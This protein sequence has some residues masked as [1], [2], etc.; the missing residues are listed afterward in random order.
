MPEPTI[1]GRTPQQQ[2]S[3][4]H[5]W[6]RQFETYRQG[7]ERTLLDLL[8][9]HD[10]R[11][12]AWSELSSTQRSAIREHY[13]KNVFPL[14]TPLAMDPAHPFPFV[15]NLSLNLLVTGQSSDGAQPVVARVKISGWS[16]YSA[17]SS[18][19]GPTV[20]LRATRRG[21]GPHPG[22]ALPRPGYHVV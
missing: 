5:A 15:S 12:L 21:D 14:V 4:C 18:H 6:V 2:I 13:L 10:I 20:A 11:I 17:T 7:V 3:E 22:C 19:S 8:A 1:D 16:G 9:H